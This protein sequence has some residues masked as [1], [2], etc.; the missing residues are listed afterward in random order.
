MNRGPYQTTSHI[1][2]QLCIGVERE[3]IAHLGQELCADRLHNEAGIRSAAQQPVEFQK[4]AALAFPPHPL[5][6]RLVPQSPAMEQ[7]K[8]P[9]LTLAIT[10]V[11]FFN[12]TKSVF[13]QRVVIGHLDGGGI[14]KIAQQSK[15]NQIVFIRQEKNL[16]LI[17]QT[18]DSLGI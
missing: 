14:A 9:D 6:F 16:E 11:E 5:L 2:R 8:T 17:Y 18:L 7:M 15:L 13:Q 3:H 1:P 4:L 10:C 12:A